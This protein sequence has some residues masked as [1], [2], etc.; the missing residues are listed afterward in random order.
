MSGRPVTVP[1]LVKALALHCIGLNSDASD[2]REDGV[3]QAADLPGAAHLELLDGV[4]HL[5]PQPALLEAMLAGWMRQQQGRFLNEEAT[6]RPR[7]ALVRRFVEF[8]NA[9][10]QIF[11]EDNRVAHVADSQ[12][13]RGVAR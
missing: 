5:D 2:A 4:V 12:L 6:I 7:I 10:Q 13:R 9:Y 8:A 3:A 11:H 1:D